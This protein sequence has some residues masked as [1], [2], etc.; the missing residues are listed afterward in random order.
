MTC[1]C[2]NRYN[3]SYEL[4]NI[5]YC[6]NCYY[7]IKEGKWIITPEN[8]LKKLSYDK[9]IEKNKINYIFKIVSVNFD[10][11]NLNDLHEMLKTC[12]ITSYHCDALYNI[13]QKEDNKYNDKIQHILCSKVVNYW[14]LKTNIGLC[15]YGNYGEVPANLEELDEKINKNKD[16][17]EYF[18]LKI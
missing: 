14:E 5:K 3:G 10:K 1:T 11:I 9:Y 8:L 6:S 12:K 17:F 15:Y 2:C 18:N 4:N 7:F 16:I 13:F